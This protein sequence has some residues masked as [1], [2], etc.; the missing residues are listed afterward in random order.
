MRVLVFWVGL[1][2]FFTHLP[3]QQCSTSHIIWTH[4]VSSFQP[5]WTTSVPQS[6][7][8]LLPTELHFPSLLSLTLLIGIFQ[9]SIF[10]LLSF[11]HSLP[12]DPHSTRLDEMS[13]L[14]RP[15]TYQAF[16]SWGTIIIAL[17]LARP[18]HLTLVS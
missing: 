12:S 3:T 18:C 16:H 1:F 9:V 15:K 10:V 8:I 7:M 13:N 11:W 14:G 5:C 2:F 6:V 4:P 17:L